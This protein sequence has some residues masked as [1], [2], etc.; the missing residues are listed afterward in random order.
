[1]E[2]PGEED[3]ARSAPGTG[4]R[5]ERRLRGAPY[6]FPFRRHTGRVKAS[7]SL[8]L[9]VPV[10]PGTAAVVRGVRSVTSMQNQRLQPFLALPSRAIDRIVHF[11]RFVC[12][13]VLIA[14]V[15]CRE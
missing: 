10:L 7:E 11:I 6:R 14:Y 8:L 2:A 15:A 9:S 3:W 1:V 5:G 13:R 12:V 4:T